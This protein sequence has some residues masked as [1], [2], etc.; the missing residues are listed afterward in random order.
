MFYS[1]IFW[2]HLPFNNWLTFYCH[3][4]AF[5]A[6]EES[7]L[8]IFLRGWVWAKRLGTS[9]IALCLGLDQS[10]PWNFKKCF[11]G[12][13]TPQFTYIYVVNWWKLSSKNLYV[14]PCHSDFSVKLKL[15]GGRY[16]HKCRTCVKFIEF[17]YNLNQ[18]SYW[19]SVASLLK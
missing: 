6:T 1:K 4:F 15:V 7:A 11:V 10:L 18:L 16:F 17:R 2:W 19:S 5:M 3:C 8:V 13:P 14:E 12:I 9:V